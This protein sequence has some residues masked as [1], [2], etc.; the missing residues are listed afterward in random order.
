MYNE[1]YRIFEIVL[2]YP[3]P[4]EFWS[5]LN[6]VFFTIYDKRWFQALST[7]PVE[8]VPE[9]QVELLVEK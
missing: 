8:D 2:N 3:S 1:D 9:A 7:T 6:L 5:L 4:K